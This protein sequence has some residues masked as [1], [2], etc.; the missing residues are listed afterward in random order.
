[1]K[2]KSYLKSKGGFIMEDLK[3]LQQKLKEMEGKDLSIQFE[4][5]LRLLMNIDNMQSIVTHTILL[6][7]NSDLQKNQE[8]E[9]VI[10]DIVSIEYV[11][12][13]IKIGMNGNYNIYI[14]T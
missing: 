3:L 14:G 1:M 7:S 5:S 8:L 4:G 11:R 10:D 2:K 13:D 12:K 6:I 9:I